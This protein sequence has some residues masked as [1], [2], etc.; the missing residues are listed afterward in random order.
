M[1]AQA[2][3]DIVG[4]DSW[5]RMMQRLMFAHGAPEAVAK[6]MHLSFFAKMYCKQQGLLTAD[7]VPVGLTGLVTHLF[8]AEP[9][10]LAFSSLLRNNVFHT[11]CTSSRSWDTIV[12]RLL[13]VLSHLLRES[14]CTGCFRTQ[15]SG[16]THLQSE[17]LICICHARY[18]Q[19]IRSKLILWQSDEPRGSWLYIIL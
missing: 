7:N 14:H 13:I 1:Q 16:G 2:P 17:C 4:R 18:K 3:Q 19:S 9:Q 15:I 8:W 6:V 11:I 10:N 5:L 12:Q